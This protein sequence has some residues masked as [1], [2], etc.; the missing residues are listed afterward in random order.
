MSFLR[1][2]P[3]TSNA[4][5]P[6]FGTGNKVFRV[7]NFLSTWSYEAL[8]IVIIDIWQKTDLLMRPFCLKSNL[9][10]Y[11]LFS[12]TKF[13]FKFGNRTGSLSTSCL[14]TY[15]PSTPHSHFLSLSLMLI[16]FLFILCRQGGTFSNVAHETAICRNAPTHNFTGDRLNLTDP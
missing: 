4:C 12:A 13:V 9:R 16:Y 5:N 7:C 1:L 8:R 15:F 6:H 11:L 14:T 10:T 2:S 3:V